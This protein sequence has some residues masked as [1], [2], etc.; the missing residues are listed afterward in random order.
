MIRVENL[1][2]KAMTRSARGTIKKPGRNV[3]Q[4]AGLNRGILKSGWALLVTRLEHKAPGRVEKVNP[5][6]TSQTCYACG[7]CAVQNRK[8]QAVFVC[9]SCGHRGNADVNAARNIARG[10][11]AGGRS[12]AARGDMGAMARS[13]KREPQLV[14]P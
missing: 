11:T 7:Y 3:A 1:N 8:S 6:Y 14:A 2:V 10:R 9:A 5:G 12:V 13:V 4:K